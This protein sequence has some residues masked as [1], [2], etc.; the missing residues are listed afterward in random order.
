MCVLLLAGCV[1]GAT[2]VNEPPSVGFSYSPPLPS[3]EM[4]VN[5]SAQATD[6]DG[7]IESYQW[8]F[9]DGEQASGPNPTHTFAEPGTY[10]VTVTVTDDRDATSTASKTVKVQ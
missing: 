3:A 7:T 5:F 2:E 6:P 10:T 4:V 9:G 8:D 1:R